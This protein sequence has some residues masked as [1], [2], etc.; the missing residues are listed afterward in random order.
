MLHRPFGEARAE[1][2]PDGRWLAYES[3]DTNQSEIYVRPYP[4][5]DKERIPVSAGIGTQPH[6]SRDGRELFYVDAEGAI[7]SVRVAETTVERNPRHPHTH[8]QRPVLPRE[9][10][11]D[12]ANLRRVAG[13]KAL[14][15]D[16]GSPYHITAV[17]ADAHRRVR[18]WIEELKRLVP[19][20]R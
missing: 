6:W 1:L 17:S 7:V 12:D 11:H 15:D 3:N 8:R 9:R 18:N 10:H 2:S 20:A 13:R 4:D 5:V 14:P 19:T 16:Q